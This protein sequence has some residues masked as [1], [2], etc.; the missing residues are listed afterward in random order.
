LIEHNQAL[1]PQER[2]LF[3]VRKRGKM[4]GA[5]FVNVEKLMAFMHKAQAEDV[6]DAE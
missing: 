3:S 5:T 6:G 4:R 2:F 1:P